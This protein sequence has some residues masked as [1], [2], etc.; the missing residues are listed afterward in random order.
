[1]DNNSQ[2]CYFTRE[3]SKHWI[4]FKCEKPRMKRKEKRKY[5]RLMAVMVDVKDL[6]QLYVK[7]VK[8]YSE[9]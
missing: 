1:M 8:I 3:Y 6:M 5:S 4:A 7:A 9:M 2:K